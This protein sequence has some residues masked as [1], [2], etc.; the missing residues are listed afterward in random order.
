VL[1]GYAIINSSGR[2]SVASFPGRLFWL[3]LRADCS[4]VFAAASTLGR[5]LHSIGLVARQGTSPI[6]EA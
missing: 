5:E 4:E 2:H 1:G 6:A 3:M